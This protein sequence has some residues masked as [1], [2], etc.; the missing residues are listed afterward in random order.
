MASTERGY[1]HTFY[2]TASRHTLLVM[3]PDVR[4][5]TFF[6]AHHSTTTNVLTRRAALV[7]ARTARLALTR[8]SCRAATAAHTLP[9]RSP[10]L[11]WVLSSA[12]ALL[13]P[14]GTAAARRMPMLVVVA[15]SAETVVADPAGRNPPS[16]CRD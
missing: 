16:S 8:Q 2:W 12:L 3:Y 10:S 4:Q 1:S 9:P 5:Q 15:A 13:P 11:S 14:D 7:T 6:V